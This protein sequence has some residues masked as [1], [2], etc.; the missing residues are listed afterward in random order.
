VASSP[1]PSG[2]PDRPASPGVESRDLR[3]SA[4][5]GVV[6]SAL[7]LVPVLPLVGSLAGVL[8]GV[9]VRRRASEGRARRTATTA[10]ALGW[11]GIA[12]YGLVLAVTLL[13]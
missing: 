7:G 5:S 13:R 6:F 1:S 9:T 10:V 2:S 3:R 12:L 11:A 4:V 8:I